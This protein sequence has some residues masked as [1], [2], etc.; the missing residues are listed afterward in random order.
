MA[1]IVFYNGNFLAA[2]KTGIDPA[3]R[4]FTLGDGVF[5]TMLAVEEGAVDA[6]AHFARLL[7]HAAVLKIFVDMDV[8]AFKSA[9]NRLIAHSS[10]YR[11]AIRT[12]ISRG[13][14]K[15]GLAPPDDQKPTILMLAS[16]APDPDK[17]PPPRL[18]IAETV[19]RNEHSPL[20]RI[21]SSNYGDNILALMEAK[22]RGAD[23]AVMLNTAGHV[24]CATAANIFALIDGALYTPPVAD[25]AMPGIT[26]RK[27]LPGAQEKSLTADELLQAE[28][29]WLTSSI[30]GIRAAASVNGLKMK[31]LTVP[32]AA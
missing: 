32:V 12:S 6:D 14:G 2:D 30:L 9:V 23:D 27:L 20:S 11:L 3:D 26:R 29:I 16:P 25:G 5:D 19:R 8:A 31:P 10:H 13:S 18:V 22:D 17:L 24:A 21:K 4:G 28:A 15:R 1:D 7:E